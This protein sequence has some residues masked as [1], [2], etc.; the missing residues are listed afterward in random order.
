MAINSE[1]SDQVFHVRVRGNDRILVGLN[2]GI[3][4]LRNRRG[5][6]Q[7]GFPLDLEFNLE[8]PIHFKA[9]STFANSR[10]TA[11]SSEGILAEF[12]L[13]GQ[14]YSR[15]QVDEPSS[16]ARFSL[17]IDKARND[18]VIVKQ[19]I[20]RLTIL[21]KSGERIFEKDYDSSNGLEV[22][23]YYLGVDKRLYI[24]RDKETGRL[25][26]YNKTGTL[27]NENPLFSDYPV[28]VVYRK[29]QSKC[30]IY[31]ANNQSVEIKS[32]TF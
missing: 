11:I 20:N 22:Q 8:N 4:E 14:E 6:I 9:G 26:L 19:D 32:F 17:A 24:V 3:V 27:V 7:E 2:N 1:I 23:Y 10:F 16:S 28:S 29:K 12:D 30:Y 18:L 5:E 13:N 25:Y 31:T 15:G 21:N